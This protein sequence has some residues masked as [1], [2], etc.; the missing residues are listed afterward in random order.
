MEGTLR[1]GYHY[2]EVKED[3]SD[4]EEKLQYY[5][6]HPD[7]AQAIIDH[8]HAYV[9]QFWD[10]EREEM[11]QVMVMEKYLRTSGQM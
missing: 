9:R 5:I 2:V 10:T 8:A 1:P 4:L 7:E 6:S 3:F 11:I